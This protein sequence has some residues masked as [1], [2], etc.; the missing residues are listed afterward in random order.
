MYKSER[1]NALQ[2]EHQMRVACLWFQ[3]EI[4]ILEVAHFCW[5]TS[6]KMSL[7][8]NRALFVEIGSEADL[9]SE[10]EFIKNI[11]E[12]L[13]ERGHVASIAMGDNL[14]SALLKARF[15]N[16]DIDSIPLGGLVDVADPFDR[17]LITRKYTEKM[18]L[19]LQDLGVLTLGQFKK[20]PM[21]EL[22][23]RFGTIGVLCRQRLLDELTISWPYWRPDEKSSPRHE[24]FNFILNEI[25]ETQ[26]REC[27]K[28]HPMTHPAHPPVHH[29]LALSPDESATR[30]P[31]RPLYLIKPK[32]IEVSADSVKVDGRSY[33]ISKWNEFNE[34]ISSETSDKIMPLQQRNYD[35]DYYQLEVEDGT[36]F[37]IF[38]TPERKFFL[39]GYNG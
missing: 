30:E 7:R 12:Y 37:T 34:R 26:G 1:T 28:T 22:T 19:A 4:S 11:A 24:Q 17:D 3:K 8:K 25:Q 18:I 16:P 6:V 27:L 9:V 36:H 31:E 13:K 35:R 29:Q 21:A 10:L 39:Q 5:P 38:E 32:P 23:S 2:K 20:L 15:N 33:K 14:L